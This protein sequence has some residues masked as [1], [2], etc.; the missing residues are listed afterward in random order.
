MKLREK[1]HQTSAPEKQGKNNEEINKWLSACVEL[2]LTTK[3]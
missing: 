3:W 1:N 2:C